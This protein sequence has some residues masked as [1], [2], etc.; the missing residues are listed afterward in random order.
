M[1]VDLHQD[2]YT[3][4]SKHEKTV[5]K[6]KFRQEGE[7]SHSE[8]EESQSLQTYQQP[9]KLDDNSSCFPNLRGK[10]VPTG[11]LYPVKPSASVWARR[12]PFHT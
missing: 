6:H 4:N 9:S 12:F 11:S 3:R 7:R 1:N 5:R 10:K 8:D 2:R